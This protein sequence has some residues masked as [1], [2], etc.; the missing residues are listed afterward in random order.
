MGT[1]CRRL[2]GAV[3]VMLASAEARAHVT[4]PRVL[5]TEQQAIRLLLPAAAR[6]EARVLR[7]TR[8]QRRAVHE[9]CAWTPENKPYRLVEGV[10][11]NGRRLGTMLVLT[12][13]TIHGPVKTAVAVD[14][15]GR[16][17][18]GAVMEL[19]EEAYVWVKPLIERDFA[20]AVK[21]RGSRESFGPMNHEKRPRGQ[22]M[23]RFYE[24]LVMTQLHKGVSLY[25]VAVL[26]PNTPS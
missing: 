5:L 10:D 19:Q 14:P 8:A 2:E 23:P 6:V 16:V 18:G 11:A 9:I 20:G 15:E 4:P 12:D 13:Y 22:S 24:T 3:L 21:G 17:T 26:R 25:E 1:V 7:L